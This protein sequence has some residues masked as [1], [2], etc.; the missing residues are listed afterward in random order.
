MKSRKLFW[1]SRFVMGMT[2]FVLV[3]LFSG[4]L[5][6]V[7]ST[8]SYFEVTLLLFCTGMELV[9]SELEDLWRAIA[10]R[11]KVETKPIGS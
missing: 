5:E 2:I 1:F 10:T 7:R 8:L 3:L 6:S 11:D 4:K 9:R